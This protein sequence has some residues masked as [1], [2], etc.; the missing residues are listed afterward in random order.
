MFRSKRLVFIVLA[1][2]LLLVITGCGKDDKRKTKTYDITVKVLNEDGNE[3]EDVKLFENK[4]VLATTNESGLASIKGLTGAVAIHPEHPNYRFD[5]EITTVN[6]R[7]TVTFTAIKTGNNNPSLKSITLSQGQ[8]NPEFAPGITEYTVEL[9]Y[10]TT[11]VPEVNAIPDDEKATVDISEAEELPGETVITVTAEDGVTT[12]E[13][14]I[15]FT[16]TPPPIKEAYTGSTSSIIAEFNGSLKD[17]K[18][19]LN[20]FEVRV[21]DQSVTISSVNLSTSEKNDS[22]IIIYIDGMFKPGE[23][24]TFSYTPT[25]QD[26]LEYLDGSKV[27]PLDNKSVENTIPAYEILVNND[28]TLELSFHKDIQGANINEDQSSFTKEELS[29]TIGYD[30][31]I[32]TVG[33]KRD[34]IKDESMELSIFFAGIGI[35]YKATFNGGKW[36]VEQLE[37]KILSAKYLYYF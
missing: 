35:K 23:E 15:K 5:P 30:N 26:D 32:L 6:K 25:G 3:V 13:Y 33:L 14:I 34:P 7:C 28:S 21:A 16:L 37:N 17:R 31:S 10:D 12:Q 2:V 29:I 20:A 11:K 18:V 4:K 22:A 27:P 24:I 36:E 19:D 8:L 1:L 9:P